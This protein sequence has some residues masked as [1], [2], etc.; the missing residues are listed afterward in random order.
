MS[1]AIFENSLQAADYSDPLSQIMAAEEHTEEEEP[2][3]V[4]DVGA[5][6]LNALAVFCRMVLPEGNPL[7]P[8]FWRTA[9][10]RVAILSYAIGVE[11]VRRLS[12]SDL[13]KPLGCSRALLS[14][15]ACELRDFGGLDHRA[16]RSDQSREAYSDRA[17]TCWSKRT[18]AQATARRAC[19]TAAAE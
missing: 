4:P 1:M 16:G 17:K 7:N 15:L 13:A 14:L 2:M 10:R 5:L 11:N 18:K 6:P 9:T 12:L 3:W 8:G 19:K